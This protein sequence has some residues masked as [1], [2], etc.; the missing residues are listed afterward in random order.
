MEKNKQTTQDVLVH[1]AKNRYYVPIVTVMYSIGS[2]KSVVD[3][4]IVASL[5]S[6]FQNQYYGAA[7]Q[8]S[9]I[10]QTIHNVP[11]VDNVR[12]TNETGN[13]LIEVAQDGSTLAGGPYYITN[14]FYIQDNELAASPGHDLSGTDVVAVIITV[15]AQNTW[16]T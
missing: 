4:S 10:L 12:F 6:F 8:L 2:T 3:A 15:R 16:T 13:K 5:D 14:D 11:G 7:I 9:D 1:R